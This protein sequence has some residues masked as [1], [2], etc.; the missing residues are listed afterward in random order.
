MMSSSNPEF[1]R[2]V[3][4]S[5]ASADRDRAITL[6]RRILDNHAPND[7]LAVLAREYLRVLG[8]HGHA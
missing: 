1:T 3:E 2:D 4:R 6:A 8:L 5:P 7:P